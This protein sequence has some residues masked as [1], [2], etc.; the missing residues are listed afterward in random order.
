MEIRKYTKEIIPDVIDFEKRLRV[1]ENFWGW[2]IDEKYI[3][4]VYKSFDSPAFDNSLSLL[5]YMDVKFVGRID[6][7]AIFSHFDS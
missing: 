4:N 5:A 7:S 2:E 6:S 3:N 1:E